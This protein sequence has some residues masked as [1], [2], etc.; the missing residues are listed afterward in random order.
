MLKWPVSMGADSVDLIGRPCQFCN[1]WITD[2]TGVDAG[3]QAGFICFWLGNQLNTTYSLLSKSTC[4]HILHNPWHILL[5]MNMP[6]LTMLT[7]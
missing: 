4:E 1:L 5:G 3:E 2:L 6:V 7:E